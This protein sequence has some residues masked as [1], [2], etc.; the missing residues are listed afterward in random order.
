MNLLAWFSRLQI[1]R[2]THGQDMVEYALL[3]GFICIAAA[4]AFPPV[5]ED[6]I[7]IFSKVQSLEV[8]AA[9]A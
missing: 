3:A 8:R 2:D 1:W 4:A 7:L 9:G 5:A 6:L